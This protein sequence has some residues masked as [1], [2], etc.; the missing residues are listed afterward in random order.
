MTNKNPDDHQD[1]GR[2]NLKDRGR[3]Q[4]LEG[5]GVFRS[6]FQGG[7]QDMTQKIGLEWR[8]LFL[9]KVVKGV[10]MGVGVSGLEDVT[11]VA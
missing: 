5:G 10:T 2:K 11:F 4:I 8:Y 1:P 7:G 9:E 6:G 3:F